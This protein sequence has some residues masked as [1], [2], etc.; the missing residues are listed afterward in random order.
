MYHYSHSTDEKLKSRDVKPLTQGKELANN[1]A[2]IQ[3]QKEHSFCIRLCTC[4]NIYASFLSIS[5]EWTNLFVYW[6]WYLMPT[7]SQCYHLFNLIYPKTLWASQNNC[8]ILPRL[9]LFTP[10]TCLLWLNLKGWHSSSLS[11]QY[12]PKSQAH[13]SEPQ[14]GHYSK[15]LLTLISLS[16]SGSILRYFTSQILTYVIML[17]T[18]ILYIFKTLSDIT[19]SHKSIFVFIL[20]VVLNFFLLLYP[21]LSLK[22]Q[23]KTLCLQIKFLLVWPV[24]EI[25]QLLSENGL[26]FPSIFVD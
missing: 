20:F 13:I 7:I 5:V 1:R 10:D 11:I 8:F 4:G 19:M 15:L 9:I 23:K 17:C 2:M 26:N 21:F 24:D 25:S 18:L 14:I 3:T 16:G 12:P 22:K 6:V